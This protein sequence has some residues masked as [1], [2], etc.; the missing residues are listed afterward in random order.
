MDIRDKKW[1]KTYKEHEKFIHAVEGILVILLMLGLNIFL[2][3]DWQTK[4]KIEEN[5]GWGEED[6]ECYCERSEALAIKN[7][8]K[9]E[10]GGEINL[11]I[12]PRMFEG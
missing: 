7:R 11:T 2:Y 6:F 12:N 10:M 5:C 1:F 8:M 3:Q 9:E 4:Q